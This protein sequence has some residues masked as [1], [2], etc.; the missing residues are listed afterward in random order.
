[1]E[2]V[3]SCS[4]CDQAGSRDILSQH[5]IPYLWPRLEPLPHDA[6]LVRLTEYFIMFDTPPTGTIRVRSNVLEDFVFN[7]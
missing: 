4:T 5:L 7:N 2:M 1:M 6:G 3:Y